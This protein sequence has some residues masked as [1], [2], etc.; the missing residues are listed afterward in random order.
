MIEWFDFIA[1]AV[2]L[3]CTYLAY[4]IYDLK[5]DLEEIAEHTF[6]NRAILLKFIE[7]IADEKV[8]AGEWTEDETF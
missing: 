2:L 8:K 4:A 7:K 3:V 6:V 1:A 5:Q